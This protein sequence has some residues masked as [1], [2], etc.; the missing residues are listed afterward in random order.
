MKIEL[1]ILK[2][3]KKEFSD[4][5]IMGVRF[6][7]KT[8]ETSWHFRYTYRDGDYLSVSEELEAKFEGFTLKL[9]KNQFVSPGVSVIEWDNTNKK[10]KQKQK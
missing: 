7:R 1:K 2:L 10:Q 4:K 8:S 6:I 5:E 3:L 9:E